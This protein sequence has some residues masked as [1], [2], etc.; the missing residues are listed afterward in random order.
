MSKFEKNWVK[1]DNLGGERYNF[2]IQKAI[3]STQFTLFSSLN[4]CIL[5]PTQVTKIQRLFEERS[6]KFLQL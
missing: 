3:T 5:E 2:C 6:R 1:Q 4:F